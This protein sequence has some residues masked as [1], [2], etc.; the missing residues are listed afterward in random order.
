MLTN[1]TRPYLIHFH[2]IL[3]KTKLSLRVGVSSRS[4]KYFSKNNLI[5]SIP[6]R[7]FRLLKKNNFVAKIVIKL[8]GNSIYEKVL[9]TDQFGHLKFQINLQNYTEQQLINSEV[10]VYEVSTFKG[11]ELSLGKT[12][13][14]LINNQKPVIITD[15]DKTLVD[16]KYKTT[17]EVYHSLT[18]PLNAFPTVEKTLDKIMPEVQQGTPLFVVSASPHFYEAPI[19][20]WLKSKKINDSGIFLKDY[21]QFLSFQNT[22][23]FSKD[24]K[25]HGTFKLSQLLNLIYM[26]EAPSK[27]ILYGDNSETDPLIYCIFYYLLAE[28]FDVRNTWEKI[29]NLEAFQLTPFQDSKL[30]NKLHM[31][32]ALKRKTNHVFKIEIYIRQI[33]G[34]K[35]IDLPDWLQK[36]QSK[37][38][39]Y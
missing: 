24:M 15:F 28:H 8:E 20:N 18:S 34:P 10:S 16:T 7:E 22:E 13:P 30:L 23:L 2:C 3:V 29:K 9:E 21:R 31:I 5:P 35:D 36:Y 27:V 38:V 6:I 39:F 26:L 19:R 32:Q 37:I 11:I 4:S 1:K 33:D 12:T 17:V 14:A 25:V